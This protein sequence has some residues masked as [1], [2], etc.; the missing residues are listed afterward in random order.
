MPAPRR[1]VTDAPSVTV[2]SPHLFDEGRRRCGA[3]Q[4]D[5]VVA[6]HD[7]LVTDMKIS[8]TSTAA[9]IS[10]IAFRVKLYREFL[11]HRLGF[12]IGLGYLNAS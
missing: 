7:E 8:M 3:I 11:A 5:E 4:P 6:H 1:V 10:T 9:T 12:R 2:T